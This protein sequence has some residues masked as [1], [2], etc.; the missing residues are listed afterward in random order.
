MRP[1]LG[2]RRD[3]TRRLALRTTVFFVSIVCWERAF[4]KVIETAQDKYLIDIMVR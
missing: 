4:E 1:N 3:D 2:C